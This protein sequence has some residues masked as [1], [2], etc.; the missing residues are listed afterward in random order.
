MQIYVQIC[1]RA[2]YRSC[3]F[4]RTTPGHQHCYCEEVLNLI[5]CMFCVCQQMS[6]VMTW[7]YLYHGFFTIL[8]KKNRYGITWH[9]IWFRISQQKY[10]NIENGM[11]IFSINCFLIQVVSKTKV[12]Y[13][14]Q[15]HK[16]GRV[17]RERIL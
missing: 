9:E 4:G 16:N 17:L 6:G 13:L 15:R 11:S 12:V 8:Y 2:A 7:L 5:S 14:L 3:S 1:I 10:I